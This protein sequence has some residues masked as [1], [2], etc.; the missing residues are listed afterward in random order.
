MKDELK[1]LLDDL[2]K[3]DKAEVIEYL[4][5]ATAGGEAKTIT[6]GEYEAY[7]ERRYGRPWAGLITAWSNGRPEI[8][9]CGDYL[10][11]D[12]GGRLEIVAKP[13]DIVRYGQKDNRGNS[14]SNNWAIVSNGYALTTTDPAAAKDH[15]R[16]L[17]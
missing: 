9:F 14:T 2:A 7:N 4:T 8:D 16:N 15:W 11:D 13:G 17:H 12:S 6:V 3:A 1:K 5:E 10:G